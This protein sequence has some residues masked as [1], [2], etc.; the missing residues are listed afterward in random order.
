MK[1]VIKFR[2]WDHNL[3]EFIEDSNADPH[4]CW[5]GTVY[6]HERQKESGDALVSGIRDLTIQQF[7][8]MVDKDGKDIYEG[9]II[10]GLMD[11]GPA[12]FHERS[13]IVHWDIEKGYQWNYWKLFSIKI[14]GNKFEN[15]E[16]LELI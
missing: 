16:L 2:V 10:R 11:F 14:E 12:G 7:T 1:R 15:P 8:G 3:K 9:D 13:A 6:C 5:N 4:I